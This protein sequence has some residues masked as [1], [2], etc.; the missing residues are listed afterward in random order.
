MP[1]YIAIV[2]S[3]RPLYVGHTSPLVYKIEYTQN[4]DV[5]MNCMCVVYWTFDTLAL[6]N[7]VAGVVERLTVKSIE[8]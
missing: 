7:T 5:L 2:S 4:I 8:L 3:G 6:T 1:L